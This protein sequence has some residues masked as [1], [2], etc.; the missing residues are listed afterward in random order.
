MVE[1]VRLS[2]SG[3]CPVYF[4]GRTG[5]GIPSPKDIIRKIIEII[6]VKEKATCAT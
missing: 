3:R 1:D 4:Y 5:G 6:P 2:V